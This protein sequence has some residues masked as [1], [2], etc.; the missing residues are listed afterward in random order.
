MRGWVIKAYIR[1]KKIDRVAL[2]VPEDFVD[3]RPHLIQVACLDR[4]T[5]QDETLEAPILAMD[6]NDVRL[7]SW[8]LLRGKGGQDLE[9]LA[10]AAR[11]ELFGQGGL[12]RV[13]GRPWPVALL[14]FVLA[15]ELVEN[16]LRLRWVLAG[17]VSWLPNVAYEVDLV[18]YSL[19]AVLIASAA[20]AL[21]RQS[22]WA[23]RLAILLAA[24]QVARTISLSPSWRAQ[25]H[26]VNWCMDCS[27][28][29]SFRLSS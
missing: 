2:V 29:C 1:T 10:R 4:G 20:V 18:L 21:W 7:G 19:Y 27:P 6:G 3:G 12:L 8:T 13:L 17:Y 14:V 23:F 28:A 26:P 16:L 22:R 15:L 24:V 5:K 25:R 11:Q 9:R